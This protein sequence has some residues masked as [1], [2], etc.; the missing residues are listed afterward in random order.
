[1]LDGL[2][3]FASSFFGRIVMVLL[4]VGM[5]G[6]GISGVITS[7]GTTTVARVGNQDISISDFQR[8]YTAQLNQVAQRYGQTPTPEQALALGVPTA[9][10]NALA[11]D[12]ALNGLASRMGLGASD[13]RLGKLLRADPNFQSV[14]GAFDQAGFQRAL[15]AN[16]YTEAEYL[17][18]LRA[19]A[20]RQQLIIATMGEVTVPKTALDI[21]NRYSGDTRSLSYFVLSPDNAL[22]PA[23]PTEEEMQ[24]YLKAHQSSYRT[25][26]TRNA[27][28]MVLSPEALAASITVTDAEIAAEYDR[29]KASLVKPE[30]RDVRQVVLDDAQ[31]SLFEAGLAAGKSFDALVA[32]SKLTP[33]DLGN[34]TR[35]KIIDS[36][37]AKAAFSLTDG[38]FVLIPGATGTRA[39]TVSNI[40]PGSQLTLDQ[41]RADI[42]ARL[43]QAAARKQFTDIL[44]QIEALRAAFK[45]LSEIAPRFKL[46][47][48]KV[49]LTETGK[50]LSSVADLPAVDDANVIKAIFGAQMGALAP[51]LSLGPNLNVWFDL[52]SV[53][54]ARDQTLDEVRDKVKT[55]MVSERIDAALVDDAKSA[56]AA[57]KSGQAL[58]DLAVARNVLPE[59][60]DGISRNGKTGSPIDGAVGTAAFDGAADLAGYARNSKGDYVVF[61]VTGVVPADPA[62]AEQARTYVENTWRDNIYSAF[63]TGVRDDAG[64][65]ISQKTLA[66]QIGLPT[67][68]N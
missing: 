14:L 27:S 47:V 28:I 24:A 55:A 53:T 35:A 11:G 3:K 43:S 34:L 46:A 22:P 33:T 64:M 44:D 60:A 26:P 7:I 56:V 39:V 49:D 57:L 62:K 38:A 9:T 17:K 15:R 32:E 59:T 29:T 41:A 12:V 19:S 42:V 20:T 31:K 36:D 2:R 65:R 66:Q 8:A 6:F 18:T 61:K 23:D 40:V 51:S 63:V 16:G 4:L 52:N 5:A 58:E 13:E 30:T 48:T 10:L 45:P 67:T 54:D 68:G 1:M 25:V 21:V 50:E 37:L